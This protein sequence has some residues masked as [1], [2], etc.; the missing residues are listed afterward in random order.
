MEATLLVKAY[1]KK[2]RLPTVSKDLEKVAQEATQANLPYERFLLLLLEQ[3]VLQREENTLKLRLKRACFPVLKTLDTFDFTASPKLNKPK[4]LELAEGRWIENRENAVL[5]GNPG[6]GKSHLAIALGVAACRK[7][8]RV[9]FFTAAT[10]VNALLEAQAHHALSRLEKQLDKFQLLILDDLGYVPFSKSGAELLF[11]I[12]ASRYE[13][14]SVLVTTNLEFSA[15]TEVMGSERMTVAL[16]DR[17]THQC[18]IVPFSG[19]SYRF[20]QSQKRA[21]GATV[22]T[23]QSAPMMGAKS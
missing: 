9:R 10:L 13:R 1:A 23:A 22:D 6:T 21:N 17:L 2:L 11:G 4:I 15:W 16:V 20:R 12:V 18:Q 5:I 19:E 14:R 8:Y 7:E 3:E